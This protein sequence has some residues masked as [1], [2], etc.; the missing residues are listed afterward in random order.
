MLSSPPDRGRVSFASLRVL[1]L[2]LA[3]LLC[4]LTHAA[5][6]SMPFRY[7]LDPAPAPPR[8]KDAGQRRPLM[9]PGMRELIRSDLDRAFEF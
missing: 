9:P 6:V 1:A 2:V 7:L 5:Q 4:W 8:A 3:L